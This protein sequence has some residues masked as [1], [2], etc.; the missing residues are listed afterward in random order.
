MQS[1]KKYGD[2]LKCFEELDKWEPALLMIIS[3]IEEKRKVFLFLNVFSD[4]I[5]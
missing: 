1:T 2:F 3:R 4:L 5:D